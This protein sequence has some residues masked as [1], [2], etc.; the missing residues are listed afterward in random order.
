MGSHDVYVVRNAKTG[1]VLRFGETGRTLDVRLTE[2]IR[3]MKKDHNF[4][5]DV[6]IDKLKTVGSKGAA[7]VIEN[8]YIKTYEKLYKKRPP[9]NFNNH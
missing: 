6:V 1:E 7:R 8:K 3:K 4:N 9:F 5:E 2:H